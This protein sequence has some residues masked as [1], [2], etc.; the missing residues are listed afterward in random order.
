MAIPQGAGVHGSV[1]FGTAVAATSN[2]FQMATAGIA[3][4]ED[5]Y[6]TRFFLEGNQ[7]FFIR[8]DWIA[9]Q[10]LTASG[11]TNIRICL[12]GYWFRQVG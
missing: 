5:V 4:Q 9:P 6:Q 3:H 8:L 12:H 10:T 11:N 2:M 7:P 1:A